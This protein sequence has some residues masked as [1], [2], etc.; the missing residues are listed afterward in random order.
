MI[1]IDELVTICD[2]RCSLALGWFE[3]LG[4]WVVDEA[5]GQRQ[6]W[7]ATACHRLAW[8]AE[9]WSGRR[10]AVPH[11]VV[12][13]HPR[14]AEVRPTGDRVAALSAHLTSER[15]ELSTIAARVDADLDPSTLRVVALVEA[16]LID[17]L[18]Q[19]PG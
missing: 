9:L 8:H 18:R 12:G 15:D 5:P 11:D 7:Y 14:P 6:R 2:A 17:L 1:P 3:T 16:D 10:P 19:R 13:P 4:R